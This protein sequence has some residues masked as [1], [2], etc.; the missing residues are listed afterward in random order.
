MRLCVTAYFDEFNE[1]CL[2]C[3]EL[4]VIEPSTK[5]VVPQPNPIGIDDVRFTIVS[6]FL[7]SALKAI[8]GNFTTM[9]AGGLS[10]YS[11]D[12]ANLVQ[13]CLGLRGKRRKNITQVDR[14]VGISVEVGTGR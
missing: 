14:V 1:I 9:D 12:F 5:Q 3:F 7:D 6:D 11:H 10:R 8:A 13:R 2:A 4:R